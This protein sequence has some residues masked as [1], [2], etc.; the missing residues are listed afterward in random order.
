MYLQS[1]KSTVSEKITL[2]KLVLIIFYIYQETYIKSKKLI[3]SATQLAE[4]KECDPHDIKAKQSFLE[5]EVK[6]FTGK[7]KKRR[8][9]LKMAVNFYKNSQKVILEI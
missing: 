5:T 6:T 9:L 8:E 7:L 4:S 3:E 2:S 1:I